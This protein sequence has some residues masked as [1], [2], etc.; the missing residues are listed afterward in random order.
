M[1]PR[2]LTLVIVF[3][4]LSGLSQAQAEL[5]FDEKW[6]F[7]APE[8]LIAVHAAEGKVFFSTVEHYGAVDLEKGTL[9]WMKAIPIDFRARTMSAG[10]SR[11]LPDVF[12][13]SDSGIVFF[14]LGGFRIDAVD[15]ASGKKLWSAPVQ[16]RKAAI[17]ASK[18]RL[19]CMPKPAELLSLD[20]RTGKVLWK[21]RTSDV[22][23]ISFTET[24]E[25]N[26]PPLID[27]KRLLIF[28]NNNEVI[29]ILQSTG[30][31][32]WRKKGISN[33][34]GVASITSDE[35]SLYLR[36]ED[37]KITALDKETGRKRWTCSL[38]REPRF[39]V[40]GGKE[41]YTADYAGYLNCIDASRGSL[42]WKKSVDGF[43]H[44]GL[45]LS[46]CPDGVTV[47]RKY[48]ILAVS[49]DGET[50]SRIP[51]PAGFECCDVKPLKDGL[52]LSSGE[53][54]SALKRSE[55]SGR[56]DAGIK[57][58]EKIRYPAHLTAR[59]R[60]ILLSSGE[61]AFPAIYEA[62]LRLDK[63]Y[64]EVRDKSGVPPEE[65]WSKRS[66][67]DDALSL[68][69][70]CAAKR[71]TEEMIRLARSLEDDDEDRRLFR[72]LAE[73]GDS[74]LADS[75]FLDRLPPGLPGNRRSYLPVL[76]SLNDYSMDLSFDDCIRALQQRL[77]ISLFNPFPDSA[78]FE[79]FVEHAGSRPSLEMFVRPGER[80]RIVPSIEDAIC[81]EEA[82]QSDWAGGR[83]ST[84]TSSYMARFIDMGTDSKG[85]KWGLFSSALR[86]YYGDAWIAE[87]R[88]GRWRDPR[89]LCL[90]ESYVNNPDWI[91][92]YT[93]KR[94]LGR[95]SDRDGL[96]DCIERTFGT[97]P[98]NADSDGDGLADGVDRNPLAA[99][100]R[101][102]DDEEIVKAALEWRAFNPRFLYTPWIVEIPRGMK[103][104]EMDGHNWINLMTT[105]DRH[106]PLFRRDCGSVLV[107]AGPP[108]HLGKDRALLKPGEGGLIYY[109]DDRSEA[110]ISVGIDNRALAGIGFCLHLS[111]AEGY[112]KVIECS[113]TWIS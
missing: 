76:R 31:V 67:F 109:N 8:P 110:W 5:R 1:I 113:M 63:L 13:A 80:R 42:L 64:R 75:Y 49:R 55:S 41:I 98:L 62:V 68:L 77:Q 35:K 36:H 92:R 78:H 32:L 101:L 22:I 97:D 112:W 91:G 17:G 18:G 26:A 93:E 28:I 106:L 7:E 30:K 100:R 14:S 74:S 61:D 33:R 47:F 70:E 12:I 25:L 87:R 23:R 34:Y 96:P 57:H 15:T 66:D 73:K 19:F 89:C 29:S 46:L 83:L 21:R 53:L 9:A 45:I 50:L 103:P 82:W 16:C 81:L 60:H 10:L 3:L 51:Y 56:D 105:E 44:H 52:L 90:Y 99:P 27:D 48:D 79:L 102:S 88:A 58:N 40:T 84:F 72:W 111:K 71:H 69:T 2:V 85:R 95:D 20:G 65:A 54:I 38:N 107:W 4:V 24:Y 94:E 43:S 59:D 37:G 104:F 108:D 11:S 86:G 39:A 6:C